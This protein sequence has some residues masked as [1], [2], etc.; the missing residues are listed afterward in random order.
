MQG[1]FHILKQINKAK[2][3]NNMIISINAEKVFDRIQHLFV[4]KLSS[5]KI[6]IE[7]KYLYW[8]PYP[9]YLPT[10]RIKHNFFLFSFYFIFLRLLTCLYIV[11]ATPPLPQPPPPPPLPPPH[12]QAQPVLSSCSPTLLKRKHK[13]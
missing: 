5:S 1:W 11:C 3:K 8:I 9:M 13:R 4:I 12:P 2:K 10:M 6:E 7:R